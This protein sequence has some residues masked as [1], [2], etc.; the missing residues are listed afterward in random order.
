MYAEYLSARS[1]DRTIAERGAADAHD[2]DARVA[3]LAS[4]AALSG[5]WMEA[6][7]LLED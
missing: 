1:T 7:R 4:A 3:Y 6:R 2:E 5:N